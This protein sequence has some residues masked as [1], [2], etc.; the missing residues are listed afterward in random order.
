MR[1]NVVVVSILLVF[2]CALLCGNGKVTVVQLCA[3]IFLIEARKVDLETVFPVLFADV[4]L[5]QGVTAKTAERCGEERITEKRI[6][7]HLIK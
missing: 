1:A 5:H 7:E 3:D 4:S 2:G 6:V